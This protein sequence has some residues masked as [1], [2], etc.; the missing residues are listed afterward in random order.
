MDTPKVASAY[1]PALL[2]KYLNYIALPDQYAQYIN[3]PQS[4]PKTEEALKDLFRCQITRFPYDN[5]TSEIQPEKTHTKVIGG[6]ESNPRSC[7]G[8]YCLEMGIFFHHTLRGLAGI[9]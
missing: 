1:T 3:Q 6:S 9:G 2:T 5:L 4:F 7:R 8:G